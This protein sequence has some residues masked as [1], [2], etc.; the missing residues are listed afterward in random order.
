MAGNVAIKESDTKIL[1]RLTAALKKDG[2]FPVRA[3]VVADL[4]T[5]AGRPNTT[6]EQIS[7][8]IIREPSL[9]TRVLALANSSM[10]SRNQSITTVTQAVMQLG[11][12][13]LSDMCAGLVLMQKFVPAAQRGGIFA[14]AV[15]RT[16]I[17]SLLSNRIAGTLKVDG[18]AEQGYLAG[19]FHSLGHLLLAYYFP[20]VYESAARRAHARG[21]DVSKSVAELLGTSS[22][23]LTMAIVNALSIPDYYRD[24]LIL[25]HKP[26]E[27]R[28]ADGARVALSVAVS[29]ASQF[30]E[31]IVHGS[32][33][34]LEEALDAVV[35]KRILPRE[36]FE[37][38][39]C[40]LPD[41]FKQHCE[42]IELDFLTLPEF[43]DRFKQKREGGELKKA[44][45]EDEL[46]AFAGFIREMKGAIKARDPV[47][48]VTTF[49]MEA[50][51]YGL[52]FDRVVLLY[53]DSDRTKLQGRMGMGK[54]L[55]VNAKSIERTLKGE[56]DGCVDVRSFKLG[57]SQH[58]G[59]PIFSD[60]YPCVAVPLGTVNFTK[61]VIY[62]DRIN[63]SK[64]LDENEQA[65]LTVLSELLDESVKSWE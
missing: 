20:Q 53:A 12:K 46:N 6:V 41:I 17:T 22:T 54:P 37:Q 33:K 34:Q 38:A 51:I 18:L 58:L 64:P 16:I 47:S 3:K 13:A 45:P 23:D 21:K 61:G 28:K 43:V 44:P 2:D 57:V 7:E 5:M 40:E 32:A 25:S 15:K 14:D 65:A 8:L 60:G 35:A 9:G 55:P 48:S 31:A 62:A 50:L 36:K 59:E 19:T 39:I 49:A 26:I 56:I 24:I 27:E 4:R 10:Y 63:G 52:N 42:L 29:T 1:E 11:M 30:A